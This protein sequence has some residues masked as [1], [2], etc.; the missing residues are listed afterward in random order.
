VASRGFDFNIGGRRREMALWTRNDGALAY[1][2]EAALVAK[3][4][5]TLYV[6]FNIGSGGT[7]VA[8]MSERRVAATTNARRPSALPARPQL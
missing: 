1:T 2:V 7:S 4:K 5:G 6:G 8:R 3:P